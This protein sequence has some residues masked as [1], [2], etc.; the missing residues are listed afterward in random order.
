MPEFGGDR[1]LD[2]QRV[3]VARRQR[4]DRGE[5]ASNYLEEAPLRV[6]VDLVDLAQAKVSA[7]Q[8]TRALILA[9]QNVCGSCRCEDRENPFCASKTIRQ[10]TLYISTR[11]PGYL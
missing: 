6:G 9:D 4:E 1:V 8:W 2:R 5:D 10:S 11:R 3:D 7:S